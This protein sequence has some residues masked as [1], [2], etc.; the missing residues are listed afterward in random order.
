VSFPRHAWI[1][2]VGEPFKNKFEC[3]DPIIAEP[4]CRL[5]LRKD[6]RRFGSLEAP[7]ARGRQGDASAAVVTVPCLRPRA[8]DFSDNSPGL[9]VQIA[10]APPP[11]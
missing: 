7:S 1:S 2:T 10:C 4:C 11:A 8:I 3:S 5:A 9:H 6:P